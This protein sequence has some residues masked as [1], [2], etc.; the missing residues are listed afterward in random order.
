MQIDIEFVR[1]FNKNLIFK[2]NLNFLAIILIAQAL[3][4]CWI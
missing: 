3:Q 4:G 1:R 2:I